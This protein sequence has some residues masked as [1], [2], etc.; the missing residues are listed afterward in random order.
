MLCKVVTQQL[1]EKK[2]KQQRWAVVAQAFNPST[3]EA[4]TGRFLSS[5]P[6]WLYR[7]TLCQKTKKKKK[8]KTNNKE[9]E[10]KNWALCILASHLSQNVADSQIISQL[11]GKASGICLF[12]IK[13]EG[14]TSLN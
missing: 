10:E 9:E 4:E 14:T 7:E 11:S 6:S 1:T 5:R 12:S 13:R 3:R 2:K 8:K